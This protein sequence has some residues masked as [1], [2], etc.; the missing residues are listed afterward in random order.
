MR[1][2]AA[3]M[4]ALVACA[5]PAPS[6]PRVAP[7]MTTRAVTRA[8]PSE[9]RLQLVRAVSERLV[10]DVLADRQLVVFL[11]QHGSDDGPPLDEMLKRELQHER[12]VAFAIR[13]DERICV[14]PD[15]RAS[16]ALTPPLERPPMYRPSPDLLVWLIQDARGTRAEIRDPNDQHLLWS[17]DAPA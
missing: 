15:P 8:L 1:S 11:E 3:V 9:Q 10:R 2:A 5:R 17:I 12:R 14:L 16:H 13:Q 4:T 7:A 6:G